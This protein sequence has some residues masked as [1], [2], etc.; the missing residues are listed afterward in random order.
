MLRVIVADDDQNAR[1]KMVRF[2]DQ[3]KYG[4]DIVGAASD[5]A[6]A[7]RMIQ[8]LQPDIVL[9]DIEMPVMSGLQVIDAVQQRCGRNSVVFIIVS[10]YENFSYAHEAI[11][12]GVND[13]LL[14]PFMPAD[15][16]GAIY[17][18]AKHIEYTRGLALPAAPGSDV[19]P[20][21]RQLPLSCRVNMEYPFDEETR[22]I[23]ALRAADAQ[24]AAAA[25]KQF[26]ERLPAADSGDA[27]WNCLTILYIEI[28]RFAITRKLDPAQLNLP[29]QSPESLEAFMRALDGL[30]GEICEHLGA[31]KKGGAALQ[32]ALKYI[33]EHYAEPLTLERVAAEA[34]VSPAYLSTLFSQQLNT[35]FVD[36]IH[37]VRIDQSIRLLRENPQLKYYEVGERVGYS[38]YKH[39]AKCFKKVK[40]VTVSQYFAQ[41]HR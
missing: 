30:A 19:P 32:L 26:F 38:S 2:I 37:K 16:C 8:E 9:I 13:Y 29:E 1:D 7:C 40:N 17:R 35:H 25:L 11:R 3:K 4:I 15:I 18:A 24:A 33:G 6:E 12:L 23:Q 21:G 27:A 34:Y 14:K 22:M 20:A 28:Y 39:Y 10:S 5:G 31:E 36:Y 41:P